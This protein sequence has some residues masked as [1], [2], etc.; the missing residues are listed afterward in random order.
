M[1]I[2]FPGP[3][4][5]VYR[6][7]IQGLEHE[8]RLNCMAM[9]SPAP[10]TAFA[11]INLQTRSGTPANAQTCVDGFWAQLRPFMH[12]TTTVTAIELWKYPTPGSL[13][14]DFI[15]ATS[16]TAPAG[17][18]GG[19]V[20]L[21]NQDTLSFRTALGGI[22]KV[23]IM[24]SAFQTNLVVALLN[25]ASGTIPQRIA[26]YVLSSAG[27]LLGRDDSFPFAPYRHTSGQNEALYRRRYRAT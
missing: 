1:A 18:A 25:N 17:T 13:D 10:G 16:A 3:Y 27:W 14:R 8:M 26:A 7:L 12:T 24:E 2:N 5:I 4:E 6:I 11:S 23:T 21:A 19:S 20:V 9:S 15:S 22:L